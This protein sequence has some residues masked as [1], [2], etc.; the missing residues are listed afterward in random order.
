[1]DKTGKQLFLISGCSF[2]IHSIFPMRKHKYAYAE[3]TQALSTQMR[4]Q[5][6][7]GYAV[8]GQKDFLSQWILCH[9]EAVKLLACHWE[10]RIPLTKSGQCAVNII[11]LVPNTVGMN[12]FFLYKIHLFQRHDLK[13]LSNL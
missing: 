1:M 11:C 12:R 13:L 7:C 8:P 3:L 5:A 4:G 10:M 9:N 6:I 2:Y